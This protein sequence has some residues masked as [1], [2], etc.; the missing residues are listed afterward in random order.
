MIKV[1]VEKDD[2]KI[3][4]LIDE[5]GNTP[6]EERLLKK[7]KAVIFALQNGDIKYPG[8]KQG[9]TWTFKVQGDELKIDVQGNSWADDFVITHEAIE[10]MFQAT[11]N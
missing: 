8:A 9:S 7:V 11:K 3:G 1:S 10:K 6:L 4:F 5:V 2:E